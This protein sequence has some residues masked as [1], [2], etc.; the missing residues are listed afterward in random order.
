MRVVGVLLYTAMVGVLSIALFIGTG[1]ANGPAASAQSR[2]Q[3]DID[4]PAA[5]ITLVNGRAITIGGWAVAPGGPDSGIASVDVYLDGPT[6]RHLGTA[7][8]GISRPDVASALGHPEWAKSGYNLDWIPREVSGG[9]HTVYV[10]ASAL[11]GDSASAA[12]AVD[13]CGCGLTWEPSL[14]HPAFRSLGPLGWEVDTGGPGVWIDRNFN[15]F[16]F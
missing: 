8:L 12:L 2:V 10:V 4:T 6:G 5:G 16:E 11:A 15:P 13:S 3:V 7:T 9:P 1:A 14:T